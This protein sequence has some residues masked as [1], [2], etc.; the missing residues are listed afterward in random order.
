MTR[1]PSSTICPRP[2]ARRRRPDAARDRGG[3]RGRGGAG[4]ARDGAWQAV[5]AATDAAVAAA[6]AEAAA[7]SG[8]HLVEVE[9]RH[10]PGRLQQASAR[11][12][13]LVEAGFRRDAGPCP[14]GAVSPLPAWS[15]AAEAV[16]GICI[17]VSWPERVRE[18]GALEGSTGEGIR[19]V[20]PRQRGRARPPSGRAARKRGRDRAKRG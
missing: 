17:P 20:H 9:S 4:G 1:R 10:N 5:A 15:L 3:V 19:R 12:A 16:D 7:H 8:A 14:G 6:L 18:A 2:G 13:E 11:A